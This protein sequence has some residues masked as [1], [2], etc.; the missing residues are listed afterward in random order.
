M[1]ILNE[2][3]LSVFAYAKGVRLI[4][5]YNLF[6]YVIL[7]LLLVAVFVLPVLI[8]GKTSNFIASI[9]PYFETQKYAEIGTRFLASISGFFLLVVLIPVFSLVSAEVH[10]KLN[11]E[12]SS[13]SL[14]QFTIDVIRGIKITFRN[15]FYQYGVLLLIVIGL[16]FLP[17]S[18]VFSI[19]GKVILFLTTS[20]F[21]GFSMMDY[22]MENNKMN[23]KK[24]IA[25]MRSHIGLGIGIGSIYYSVIIIN[26]LKI[27]Q[28]TFGDIAIYWS[29]FAEAI[30]A[31]IGVIAANIVMKAILKKQF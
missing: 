28:Q 4:P 5:K 25:F 15:L 13:F 30:I 7:L 14:Q 10:Q 18:A 24:S 1:K 21:Y 11:N 2:F 23:Y 16:K 6:K 31:F 26:K 22:A 29:V 12:K 9:I 3:V 17:T 20:Y 19:L 8:I 27:F